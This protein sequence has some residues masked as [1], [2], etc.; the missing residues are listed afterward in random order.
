MKTLI[1]YAHLLAA[2]VSI[3]ILVIQDLA[4]ALSRGNPLSAN[5]VQELKKSAEIVAVALV[6]LWLSGLTLV[7]LG[8]LD[9]PQQ[10]LF[11]QKLW[12]KFNVVAVLTINGIFLHYYSFPR[13][14]SVKGILGLPKVEQILVALTG[15]V[16]SVSWFFACYL[17]IARP[18]NYTVE[19]SFIMA[20]YGGLIAVAFIVA[21][22]VLRGLR[23]AEPPL[24]TERIQL[25]ASRKYD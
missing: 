1:V 17:G 13:V 19:F 3:G 2:C 10:Y 14:T 5:A 24:L 22:E 21:C 20:I 15:A 23:K 4:I 6:V 18:W 16:S 11:N 8:Y 12:A 9:N 25:N 7:L